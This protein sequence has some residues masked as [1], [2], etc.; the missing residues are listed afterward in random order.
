MAGGASYLDPYDFDNDDYV[1]SQAENFNDSFMEWFRGDSDEEVDF[2]GFSSSEAFVYGSRR[3]NEFH[4][5]ASQE[6]ENV[7]PAAHTRP[8]KRKA[9]PLR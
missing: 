5:A 1:P 8:R 7:D 2:P 3:V 6:K 9:D 4:T